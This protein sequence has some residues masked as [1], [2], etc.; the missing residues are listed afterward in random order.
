MIGV[1]PDLRN[2]GLGR[3]VLL[4]GLSHL[5]RKGIEKVELTADAE[6]PAARRLYQSVGFKEALKTEW[7]E[8][9]LTELNSLRS[10]SE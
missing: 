4:T 9:K 8:K 10:Q 2:Q 3:K 1:V 5:K 7:Y 6:D